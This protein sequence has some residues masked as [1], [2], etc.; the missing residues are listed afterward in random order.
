MPS[1]YFFLSL[2]VGEFGVVGVI[3][4]VVALNKSTKNRKSRLHSGIFK[5]EIKAHLNFYHF[6]YCRFTMA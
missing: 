5:M 6:K 1:K 2:S 4:G 3:E